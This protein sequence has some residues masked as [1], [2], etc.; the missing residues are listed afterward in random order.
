[1]ETQRHELPF[2]VVDPRDRAP[3]LRP[4]PGAGAPAA[5]KGPMPAYPETDPFPR[6]TRHVGMHRHTRVGGEVLGLVWVSMY[7]RPPYI[8][9]EA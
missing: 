6:H 9:L 7:F 2:E 4:T 3:L 5:L 8:L 1:M